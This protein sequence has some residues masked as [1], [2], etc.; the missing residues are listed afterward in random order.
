M[1][2]ALSIATI[3]GI[4]LAS[5]GCKQ[6][7]KPDDQP[8]APAGSAQI[9]HAKIHGHGNI[10]PDNPDTGSDTTAAAG[11]PGDAAENDGVAGKP[12]YRDDSG[13]VHGPGGPVDMGQETPCDLSRNHCMRQPAWFAAAEIERGRQFRATPAF[14]F[15]KAWYD[16]RGQPVDKGGKLYSTRAAGNNDTI[17]A[18]TKIIFFEAD[19]D[20]S[21]FADSEFDSLTSS[22][23]EAGVV[24]SQSGSNVRVSSWGDIP[25][26]TVRLIVDK[27][28]Y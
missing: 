15:E 21:K 2:I 9:G 20:D 11:T 25:K 12:P 28:S 1:R 18:G 3:A 17:A 8:A 22:R 4:A 10:D 7:P 26:D 23:W 27:Q 16:W 6:Q 24:E 13:H 5:A 19:T 14:L